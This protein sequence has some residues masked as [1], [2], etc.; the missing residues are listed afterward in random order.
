[1]HID[2]FAQSTAI[3]LLFLFGTQRD[4]WAAHPV[5]T[6]SPCDPLQSTHGEI[7][8]DHES[9]FSAVDSPLALLR[10]SQHP[11]ILC[12]RS[13]SFA[14]GYR[15]FDIPRQAHIGQYLIGSVPSVHQKTYV[16][17]FVQLLRR[18]KERVRKSPTFSREESDCR[19]SQQ[20]SFVLRCN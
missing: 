9:I 15:N 18:C 10:R 7:V 2:V 4:R 6:S 16:N 8:F 17:E 20:I 19:L 5:W 13:K 12:S 14:N 11:R 1:M 3:A